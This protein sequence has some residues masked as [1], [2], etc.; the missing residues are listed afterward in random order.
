MD[1]IY[2]KVRKWLRSFYDAELVVTDSFHACVFS[3]IFGKQ[4][5]VVGNQGRGL[6]RII[7]LLE[8]FGLQDRLVDC[9][10]DL[11]KMSR[12]DFVGVHKLLHTYQIK[13][14]DFLK[15]SLYE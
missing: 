13:S 15:R 9:I 10:D 3:I 11:G 14:Q 4:F 8:M 5:V 7:S 12:I 1:N 6:T 2:K